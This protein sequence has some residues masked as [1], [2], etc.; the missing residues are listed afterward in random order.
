M[1]VDEFRGLSL[2]AVL[3]GPADAVCTLDAMIATAAELADALQ[4][5]V[6]NSKGAPLTAER[7]EALREDVASFQALLTLT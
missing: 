1:P 5:V 2:F 4:G 7:A 6:Q 3:P